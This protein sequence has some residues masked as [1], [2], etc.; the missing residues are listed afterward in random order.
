MI[1][2]K[3]E[4][5]EKLFE[6]LKMI[7]WAQVMLCIIGFFL[8]RIIVFDTF[9]TL[10][11]C[12]IGAVYFDKTLRKWTSIMSLIGL[13]SLGVFDTHILKY[14]F[15]IILIVLFRGYMYMSGTKF[16]LRNQAIITCGAIFCI[17]T[18]LVIINGFKV[19]DVLTG[20]LEAV[21]SIGLVVILCCSAEIISKNR[22]VQLTQKENISMAFFAACVLGGLVDFYIQVPLFT[23]IYFRD[24]ITFVIIIAIT[25]LGGTNIGV[26]M[27]L[28][29]STLLV[30]IGYMPPHFVA[31]YTLAVLTGTI[32]ATLGRMGVIFATGI[33]LLLGFALFNNRIIDMQIFGAYLTAYIISILI[34][35]RYFGIAAWFACESSKEEEKH[36][37]RVQKIITEKLSQFSR[38]FYNLS[39]TFEKISDKKVFLD[40]KD[41]NHIIEDTGEKM[42]QNCSMKE[43]CWRDYIDKTYQNAYKMLDLIEQKGQLK[44]GDIPES[45][46]KACPNAESF[47]CTLSFKLDLF[48]QNLMWKN[49]FVESRSLVGQQFEAIA[50]SISKLCVDIEK[51]FYFNKEDENFIKEILH[52]NG[53]KTKDIMVLENNGRKEEIHVYTPYYKNDMEIK[54]GIKKAINK[55]LDVK[56]ETERLECNEQEKYLYFK[57]KVTKSYGVAAGAAFHAKGE[58]SGDVYS[59]MEVE[60]GKYLLALADGMGSGKLASE[61]STA[62]IEL[63]E[64]FMDSGFK[65]DLAV[66]II[67]SVLVLKSDIENFSTMDITLIDEYTGV[68]EFLKLGAATSF[69]LRNNEVMTIQAST[70]PIGILNDVDIE[71][72]KKQLKDGD[73]IIMVTDGMLQG[74]NELLGKEDTFKHFILEANTNN[75]SYMA[76]YLMKKS[77]DLLGNAENDD[78]TIIVA[79]IWQKN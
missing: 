60:E 55:A 32:F 34:P 43:F 72:C 66:K 78:M 48:K 13:I 28:V 10:S 75:P 65:N 9:Y 71:V 44:I 23:R 56:V 11:V 2:T 53:I 77:R 69:I 22:T 24:V 74:E 41:I 18:L 54:E 36:L 25:Y 63:L 29:M 45:F 17:N 40:E 73:V 68:A 27:T 46:K 42:C 57:F 37:M 35:K 67:N 21:I 19:F 61:E 6:N 58:I 70:L 31:I 8:S 76:E 30:I 20:L 50:E 33:G 16:T 49:R 14:L 79:R 7:K 12:Y 26:T 38:A 59:C 64:N 39:H 1:R 51:E 47:A 52:S 5:R 4:K 15:I 3:E 62:T